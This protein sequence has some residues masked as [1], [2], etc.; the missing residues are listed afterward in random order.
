MSTLYSQVCNDIL[1]R[2]QRGELKVGDRLPPEKDY[3]EALGISRTT[4]RLAYD[5]LQA[6]GV[7]K[8]QKKTGTKIISATPKQHFSMA[9]SDI[10]EL[11]KVG[12]ETAFNVIATQTVRT[13]DIPQLE[14]EFSET[15]Y[16]LEVF[17]TRSLRGE[18]RPFSVNHV[19][20]PARYAA[21][22]PVLHT[23]RSS[24]FQVI[25]QTFDVSVGQVGQI[26][27]AI[28]CPAEAAGIMG[29]EPN[30]PALEIDARLSLS[31]GTLMEV[32]VAVFDPNRFQ[33]H[34]E[35]QIDFH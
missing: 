13:E 31:D 6:L 11:L 18:T 21:I 20:V 1:D 28:V 23:A 19:Y 26:V 24:V 2:I 35:V 8:R 14:G 12:S 15:G 3:A 29:L 5:E 4:L 27:R 34:T 22:E 16:W 25:E 10:G 7:L 30:A 17:G 33:V 9:T 32:S